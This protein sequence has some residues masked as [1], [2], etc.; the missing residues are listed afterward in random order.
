MSVAVRTTHRVDACCWHFESSTSWQIYDDNQHKVDHILKNVRDPVFIDKHSTTFGEADRMLATTKKLLV[1]GLL[2]AQ[3]VTYADNTRRERQLVWDTQ[4]LRFPTSLLVDKS[5][6][7]S[8][9]SF[10]N[11]ATL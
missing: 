11:I 8:Q 3:N 6:K 10:S 4:R 9:V 2:K 7:Y 5:I 1:S